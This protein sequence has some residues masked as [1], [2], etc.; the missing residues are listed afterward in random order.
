MYLMGWIGDNGD[1]DN[2]LYT[3]LDKDSAGTNN[4]SFY[5]SEKLHKVLIDAQTETNESKRAALYEKAQQIIHEDAPWVPLEYA[6][7]AVIGKSTI[8][9]YVPS[10]TG[11]E[12]LENVTIK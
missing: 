11:S 1:P 2:F 8:S 5:K 12:P 7:A 4:L 10:P 9:G 3:L 6:K